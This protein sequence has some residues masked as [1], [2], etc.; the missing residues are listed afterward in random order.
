[1]EPRR[2]EIDT[3]PDGGSRVAPEVPVAIYRFGSRERIDPHDLVTTAD[4]DASPAGPGELVVADLWRGRAD[5]SAAEAEEGFDVEVP[6]GG[7]AWRLVEY[8]A[9]SDSPLHRTATID[10]DMV[11]AG[12][13]EL[14]LESGSVVLFAGD[15]VLIPGLVHAWHTGEKPCTM[16]VLQTGVPR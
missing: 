8:G 11:L 5:G 7:T 2:I 12:E 3:G 10:H 4:G 16:A 6:P 15:A 1:M 9:H 14:E 13:I